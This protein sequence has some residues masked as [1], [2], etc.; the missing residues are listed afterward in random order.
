MNGAFARDTDIL[1]I[2]RPEPQH[3]LT[4]ILAKGAQTVNPLVRIGFQRCGGLQ[5]KLYLAFQ[6]NGA[7]QKHMIPWQLHY[8]A[9]FSR[10][11][12]NGFLYGHSI[13]C[14][15]ITLGAER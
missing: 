6:F 15:T 3:T 7:G 5:M 10:T 2:F 11:S 13:I 1:G 14:H 8:S 4:T 12:V 9:T